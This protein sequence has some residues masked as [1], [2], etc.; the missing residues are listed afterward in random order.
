V[1]SRRKRAYRPSQPSKCVCSIKGVVKRPEFAARA[2]ADE[3]GKVIKLLVSP[4]L[5]PLVY[6]FV[7]EIFLFIIYNVDFQP[8]Q[9]FLFGLLCY[10][11][12]YPFIKGDNITFIETFEH[13][14]G[15]AVLNLVW[16]RSF[17][18]FRVN[19]EEDKSHVATHGLFNI[20][21]LTSLAPYYLPVFTI[22][23][24]IF[25]PFLSNS[26]R[27]V[28]DF[29]IGFTL[30]FHYVALFKKEFHRQQTDIKKHTL[31]FSFLITCLMNAVVLVIILCA[32]LEDYLLLLNYLDGS[33]TRAIE[34]YKV[35][36]QELQKQMLKY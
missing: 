13:E 27:D 21:F 34:S 6:A 20:G 26:I 35:V 23:L 22:P 28:I 14:L 11:L 30:G 33:I 15:H 16:F 9:W 5:I 19:P 25:K 3:M 7:Y 18:E 2:R 8:V 32:V 1:T 12:I 4:V 31:V 24:L 36:F 10:V 29:L 17:D